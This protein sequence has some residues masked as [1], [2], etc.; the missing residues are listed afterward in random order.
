M[1]LSINFEE[2]IN[3]DIGYYQTNPFEI[4]LNGALLKQINYGIEN[5]HDKGLSNL[6]DISDLIDLNEFAYETSMADI[7]NFT[8]CVD[9][10]NDIYSSALRC[11]NNNYIFGTNKKYAWKPGIYDAIKDII[12]YCL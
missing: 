3:R 2:N 6:S 8:Q 10:M 5:T 4:L 12:Y 7:V 1:I 9:N 11:M